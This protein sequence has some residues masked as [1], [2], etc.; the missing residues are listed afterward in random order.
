MLLIIYD[1]GN[2]F[3][4]AASLHSD[5]MLRLFCLLKFW[6]LNLS[7]NDSLKNHS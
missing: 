5:G 3:I 4:H 7:H 1:I 6:N 2:H